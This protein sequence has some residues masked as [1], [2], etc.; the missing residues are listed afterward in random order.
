[1]ANAWLAHVK[2]TMKKHKGMKF[3]HV[4]KQA[5]KTYKKNPKASGSKKSK[6]KSKR[7]RRVHKR[8]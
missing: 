6:S 7:R 1:M 5:A 4:L 2:S 3:K 8:K